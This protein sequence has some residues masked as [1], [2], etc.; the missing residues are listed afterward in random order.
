MKATK[1]IHSLPGQSPRAP[2]LPN[3]QGGKHQQQQQQPSP[4]NQESRNSE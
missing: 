1:P 3:Q 2:P 4:R